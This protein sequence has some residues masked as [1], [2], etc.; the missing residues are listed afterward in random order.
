[1]LCCAVP[2]SRPSSSLED[3]PATIS[4][5]LASAVASG[6]AESA[7]YWTYHLARTAFFTATVSQWCLIQYTE[8]LAAVVLQI[9]VVGS[10]H[11]LVTTV[12]SHHCPSTAL[13][14]TALL[15]TR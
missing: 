2:C 11:S 6:D 1:M 7:A 8:G 5:L 9:C 15:L 3:L 14:S 10:P 4:Q 13:L 12:P